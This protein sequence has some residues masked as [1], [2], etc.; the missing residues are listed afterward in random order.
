[1]CR[2]YPGNVLEKIW[3]F[4]VDILDNNSADVTLAGRSF[5]I[6]GRFKNNKNVRKVM[7]RTLSTVN[8]SLVNNSELNDT[9]PISCLNLTLA[10]MLRNC[11]IP[12]QFLQHKTAIMGAPLHIHL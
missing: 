8:N 3:V 5:H 7:K 11:F 4:N 1:M 6:H 12:L 2:K 10:P 9:S